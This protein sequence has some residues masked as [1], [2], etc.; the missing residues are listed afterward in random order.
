MGMGMGGSGSRGA[1][2]A[3]SRGLRRAD[4]VAEE[5]PPEE[6]PTSCSRC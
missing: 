2:A 3:S 4:H 6:A 5:A 1:L